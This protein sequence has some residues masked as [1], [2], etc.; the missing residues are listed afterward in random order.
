M[1]SP[2]P[3]AFPSRCPT[4][5]LFRAVSRT[6]CNP[7]DLR[8]FR[9]RVR[10]RLEGT[11]FLSAES[12]PS[13]D[14]AIDSASPLF[15]GFDGTTLPS[16][17][18]SAFISVLPPVE[19]SDRPCRL[20]SGAVQG[21]DGLSRFSRLECLQHARVFDSAAFDSCLPIT[22]GSMLPSP[23]LNGIGTR[24]DTD[25]GAQW[26]ACMDLHIERSRQRHL[27]PF[28]EGRSRWL[29]VLRKTLS[30]SIPSR[31]IPALSGLVFGVQAQLRFDF[32]CL[33][34]PL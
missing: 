3:V 25:F 31:F 29:I 24:K 14:S 17:F 33:L 27:R 12:L 2:N 18:P 5:R 21:T 34:P 22:H 7:L 9:L 16:D 1:K 4:R 10:A 20:P 8:L 30:F 23:H 15:A 6:P 32:L 19:F 28:E 11:V 26:L 13:A